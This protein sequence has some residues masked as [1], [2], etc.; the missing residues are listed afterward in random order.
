MY[1]VVGLGNPGKRYEYTKHNIGFI[2]VDRLAEQNGVRVNKLRHKALTGEGVIGGKKTMLV[3]PQTY[4]NLSGESVISL[5]R[6]FDVRPEEL[7]LIYDDIDIPMGMLR[8]RRGG[9]AGTHNGMRSVI[10]H[11]REDCFPRVRVGIG[12]DRGEIPL[13]D[14]VTSKFRKNEAEAV[15]PAILRAADA[16]ECILSEGIDIAMTRYNG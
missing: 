2:T 11:L 12:A 7:I 8:I 15:G 4:M 16:V 1:V 13:I 6:Y 3:K 10:F 14:Y 5:V 9:S